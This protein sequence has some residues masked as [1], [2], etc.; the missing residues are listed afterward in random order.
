MGKRIIAQRRGRGTTTYRTPG[1]RFKGPLM[2]PKG[3]V[4]GKIINIIH[5]PGRTA[6]IMQVQFE[7]K[8]LHIPAPEKVNVNMRIEAGTNNILTGNIVPLKSIPIGQQIFGIEKTPGSGPAFCLAAGTATKIVDKTDTKAI[9]LFKSKKQK[10]FDLNCRA[11]IGIVAG[12]G[13]KEKPFFKAGKKFHSMKARNRLYPRTAGV[14]MNAV[15]HPFGS[16]RGRHIGKPKTVSRDA[17]PGRKVGSV[18]SRR[19]GRRK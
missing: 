8:V 12:G 11:T 4:I 14:A 18:G 7:K 6:P 9:I 16:G 1:F 19:T 5:D 13:R 15:D 10:E 3:N 2:Y 17:P